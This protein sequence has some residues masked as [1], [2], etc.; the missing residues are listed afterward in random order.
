MGEGELVQ[1]DFDGGR[2]IVIAM[3]QAC[4][5]IPQRPQS[6]DPAFFHIKMCDD[7]VVC[8]GKTSRLVS[9]NDTQSYLLE[10]S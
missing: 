7:S 1:E 5:R 4:R 3:W 10:D 6:A 2:L 9:G 8:K